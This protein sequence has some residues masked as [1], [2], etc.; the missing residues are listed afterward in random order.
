MH[1]HK[2]KKT[3][4]VTTILIF[5][6]FNIKIA[7]KEQKFVFMTMLYNEKNIDR[8][9]EY[10]TC[11]KHNLE[12][13]SI[14]HIHVLYDIESDNQSNNI[15]AFLQKNKVSITY[16]SG[17]ATYGDFFN[18]AKESYPDKYII[19]ANADI[20]FDDSL[21]LLETF[22]FTDVFLALTRWNIRQACAP[23]LA[24]S[25]WN[26]EKKQLLG[27]H[28]NPATKTSGINSLST[29]VWIFKSPL[30]KFEHDDIVLGTQ[31][32]DPCIVY[33]AQKAGLK[34][35]NPCLTIRCYHL[36]Q[37]NIRNWTWQDKPP[38]NYPYSLL[39]YTFL[40]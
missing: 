40:N 31:W 16:I 4:F 10:I 12:H 22:D 11:L 36:H 30:K 7:S 20:F 15:L 28:F 37:T 33:Q 17:R 34:V 21:R 3:F 18:L 32:C 23:I 19:I 29:D 2:I 14:N 13:P 35:I 27:H 8:Q 25:Q 9:Q 6:F 24:D 39:Q 38:K 1:S 5:L 26:Q